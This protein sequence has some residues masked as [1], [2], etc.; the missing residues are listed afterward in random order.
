METYSTM[1]GL[2]ALFLIISAVIGYRDRQRKDRIER[3]TL[4]ESFG[5][6]GCKE[7]PDGRL[8]QIQASADRHSAPFTIDAI[9]WND[10]DL[11]LLY[12]KMDTTCSGAG[13]EYLY[14]L[15]RAPRIDGGSSCSEE[16]LVWWAAHD[17]ERIDVQRILQTLGRSSKY[18]IYDYLDLIDDLPDR[19]IAQ[20]LPALALPAISLLVMAIRP[21]AGLLCLLAS[22][23]YN[24]VTYFRT[25]TSRFYSIPYLFNQFSCEYCTNYT[26]S[27]GCASCNN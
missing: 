17:K 16:G 19:R 10:L 13:E 18:S 26:Y 9:T 8:A 24:M 20:D 5:K 4:Q 1:F 12:Q 27:K 2:L 25:N 23:A 7:Y 3:Q 21:A 14:G 15:L 22:L 11:D 6:P